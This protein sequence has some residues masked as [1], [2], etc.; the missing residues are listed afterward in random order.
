MIFCCHDGFSSSGFKFKMNSKKIAIFD[1]DYTIIN[2][3]S[4]NY[5]NKIVI[6][7]ETNELPKN[8]HH[9]TPSIAQLNRFKYSSEIENLHDNQD[10]TVRNREV[11]KYMHMKHK[12]SR[13]KM[14]KSL[15]EVVVSSP[16]KKLFKLLFDNGFELL[17]ISDSNTFLIETILRHND[18][19]GYFGNGKR[20]FAN[21]AYFCENGCL[22]LIPFTVF[23]GF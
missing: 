4:N 8:N 19:L 12:I 14:E 15:K 10:F 7:L 22:N 1:F 21:K 16:M 20:I 17:I 11:Y 13:E 9:R 6:E 5:L 3:N 23:S 2:A 18:L